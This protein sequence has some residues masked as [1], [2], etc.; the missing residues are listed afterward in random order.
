MDVRAVGVSVIAGAGGLPCVTV[1]WSQS[2]SQDAGAVQRLGW[3]G[4]VGRLGGG[5]RVRIEGG[6]GERAALCT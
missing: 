3:V 2:C 5:A 1:S 6:L 4:W